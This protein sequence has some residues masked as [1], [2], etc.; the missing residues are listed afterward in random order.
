MFHLKLNIYRLLQIYSSLI[1]SIGSTNKSHQNIDTSYCIENTNLEFDCS[2]S[3]GNQIHY[4]FISGK[5]IIYYSKWLPI[6]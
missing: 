5:K 1:N 2:L 4:T 3:Q 6:L